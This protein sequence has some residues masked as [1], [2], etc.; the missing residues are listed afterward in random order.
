MAGKAKRDLD[1]CQLSKAILKA[2]RDSEA[3]SAAMADVLPVQ[4]T[5]A[6]PQAATGLGAKLRA[7]RRELDLTLADVAAKTGLTQGYLSQVERDLASPSVAS[8]LAIC[9]AVGTRIGELFDARDS[10]LVRADDRA[11]I[12]FGGIGVREFLLS[13]SPRNRLQAIW[14]ELEPG[15]TGGDELWSL[16][17]EEELVLVLDGAVTVEV[18][19]VEHDLHRGDALTFDPRRPHRFWNSSQQEP[20][21]ALFVV[22]PSPYT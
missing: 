2:V 17:A 10:M 18:G 13:P 20:A 16:P 7:R 8:L 3:W 6:A 5:A 11:P 9:D 14:S 19:G 22:T 1:V 4:P 12:S 21:R 15:G